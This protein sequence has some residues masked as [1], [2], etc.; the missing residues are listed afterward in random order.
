MGGGGGRGIRPLRLEYK[1]KVLRHVLNF[2]LAFQITM[3]SKEILA[4]IKAGKGRGH[5]G[6]GVRGGSPPPHLL[7]QLWKS[8]IEKV[9]SDPPL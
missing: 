8:Y 6:G 9:F 1:G 4:G 3:I 5:G 7:E 2:T